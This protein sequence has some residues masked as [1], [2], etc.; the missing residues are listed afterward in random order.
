M[1]PLPKRKYPKARQGARRSHLAMKAKLL[2]SCP[3]CH[4]PRL[5]HQVCLICGTYNGRQVI[6]MKAAKP[7]TNE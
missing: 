3:Q 6:E 4:S 1:G 5:S 2:D 7:K